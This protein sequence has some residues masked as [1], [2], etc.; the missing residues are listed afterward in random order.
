L[1]FA[2]LGAL[3]SVGAFFILKGQKMNNNIKETGI[4]ISQKEVEEFTT[5]MLDFCFSSDESNLILAKAELIKAKK[6]LWES[7]SYEQ[8]DL[9]NDYLKAQER[10]LKMLIKA[11]FIKQQL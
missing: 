9:F 8:G 7:F 2:F 3:T 1:E 11:K 5:Q 10:Y 6:N 4:Y